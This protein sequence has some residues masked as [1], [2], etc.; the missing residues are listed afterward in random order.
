MAR[1]ELAKYRALL[2]QDKK[3]EEAKIK[4]GRLTP[5]EKRKYEQKI[6]DIEKALD[7][8]HNDV[9][10]YNKTKA[11]YV[12]F[13]F[14]YAWLLHDPRRSAHMMI[15]APLPRLRAVCRLRCSQRS[16]SSRSFSHGT[17]SRSRRQAHQAATTS[18]SSLAPL[19][20]H[21]SDSSN[22][23]RSAR[24]CSDA[25]Q[26]QL[27]LQEANNRQLAPTNKSQLHTLAYNT[28]TLTTALSLSLACYTL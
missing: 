4:K 12:L 8:F 20:R 3:L 10:G 15:L 2:F 14:V 27:H 17:A 9:A 11:V 21:S 5:D 16:A 26:Q 19:Y 25:L 1:A 28:C 22:A 18:C 13:A 7:R 24:D 6:E 23:S